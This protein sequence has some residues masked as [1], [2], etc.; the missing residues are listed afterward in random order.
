MAS[1]VHEKSPNGSSRFKKFIK[2]TSK[3]QNTKKFT[4][5]KDISNAI[6]NV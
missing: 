5:Q 6:R 4:I 3:M 2:K 1:Q